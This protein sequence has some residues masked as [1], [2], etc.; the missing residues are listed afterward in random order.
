MMGVLGTAFRAVASGVHR[1]ASAVAAGVRRA[2]TA[3]ARFVK[4]A[5]RW[6]AKAARKVAARVK[7]W[8][9][10]AAVK[11]RAV[12]AHLRDTSASRPAQS[13]SMGSS[14]SRSPSRAPERASSGLR[15]PGWMVCPNGHRVSGEQIACECGGH[16]F[17]QCRM[18]LGA[19]TCGW[20]AMVPGRS[21]DCNG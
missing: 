21:E 3:V 2:A 20:S 4:V 18:R 7:V 9:K 19:R 11:V 5:G 6:L 16:L 15:R 1:A 17:Y 14:P 13:R 10:A 12:A 8:A